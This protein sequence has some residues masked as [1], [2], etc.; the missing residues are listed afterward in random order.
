MSEPG[1]RFQ[2][3]LI[4]ALLVVLA[5]VAVGTV[6]MY[7]EFR[8]VLGPGSGPAERARILVHDRKFG[9]RAQR[10]AIE[11]GDEVLPLLEKESKDFALLDGRNAFWIADVLGGIRS[12]KSRAVLE[13]LHGR[14]ERLARL[15]GVA[16]LAQHGALKDA[17]APGSV[18]VRSLFSDADEDETELAIVGLGWSKD[19]RALPHLHGV[20]R[21]PVGQYWYHA[22][23]CEAV[24]RIGS[25]DSIPVLRDCLRRPDFHALPE[26]FRALVALGDREA[27]PLAIA[28]I[29]PDIKGR[30]SGFV[31]EELESVT[32][33]S[34]GYDRA[35]WEGW[36]KSVA[37]EWRIPDPFRRPWDEQEH[38]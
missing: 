28:R 23:A 4:V 27:V 17:A 21:K 12:P 36:W 19:P 25:P 3:N 10:E 18:L 8:R 37:A 22:R 38:R 24:A 33:Q 26:S 31:V 16:G 35:A 29:A 32:G 9:M 34:H 20:F 7:L 1:Q 11:D 6:W 5:F 2:R 14:K 13:D 15:V 30:N